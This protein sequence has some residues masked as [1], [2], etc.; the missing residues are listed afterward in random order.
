MNAGLSPDARRAY[1]DGFVRT[2]AGQEHAPSW[3]VSARKDAFD[4]FM[5]KGWPTTKQVDWRFT[6]VG[7][8]TRLELLPAAIPS[9]VPEGAF[10]ESL[11]HLGRGVGHR[12]VFV[13]GHYLLGHEAGLP[14]PR[15][16][17]MASLATAIHDESK[18]IGRVL[19]HHLQSLDAFTAL[20]AAFMTDGA[21][22]QIPAGLVVEAPIFLVFLAAAEGSASFPR[23]VV[24][25][26]AGSQA[27]L[28][29]I[30]LGADG[31]ATLSD[32]VTE[33]LLEPGA[34]LAYHSV[35]KFSARGFHIGHLAV[36]QKAGSVFFAHSLVLDGQLVRNDA[37]VV[38][39]EEN[40]ACQLDGVYL[41]A[42]GCHIDNQTSID[43]RAPKCRSRESYRG[44]V[45]DHGQAVWSGR[46]IV[47]PGAQGT[48]ARQSNR[49]LILA[50]GAVVHSKPHLEIFANDVKC[51]HGAT[52]GRLDPEALFYLRSRGI[53]E[54]EA[55]QIL[56]AAFLRDGLG[57]VADPALRGELEGILANRTRDL[58]L[59]GAA[60]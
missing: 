5:E 47:R 39:A 11:F 50:D 37:H 9:T 32:A 23:T 15:G 49:N 30:H 10:D 52:T 21:F 12:M 3:L 38:L 7:P 2:L 6:D 14:P 44:V 17:A 13:D 54:K 28:V 46:A 19:G 33:I 20:N 58:I 26:G 40:C 48:D 53:G 16:L 36:T 27:T 24:V 29:E 57:G 60:P 1:A 22:V 59:E 41:A 25:A 45:S 35:E 42:G 34:R 31:R 56:I 43:H 55:N 51:S 8:L 18:Q 4:I